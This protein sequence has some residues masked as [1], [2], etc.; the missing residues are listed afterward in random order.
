MDIRF[1]LAGKILVKPVLSNYISITV[2]PDDGINYYHNG[3]YAVM[4]KS[5]ANIKNI[6]IKLLWSYKNEPPLD[7]VLVANTENDGRFDITIDPG[8]TPAKYY[9]LIVFDADNPAT[10]D[11]RTVNIKR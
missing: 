10:R 9:K 4:W 8:I 1:S 2:P 11:S 7:F 6:S 5:S 3:R